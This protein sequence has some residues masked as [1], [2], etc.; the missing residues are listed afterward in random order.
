VVE[1]HPAVARVAAG[2][3][4]RLGPRPDQ[5]HLAPQDVQQLGQLIDAGGP[6]EAADRG[7]AHV[8]GGRDLRPAGARAHR[9]ELEHRERNAPLTDPQLPEED[10]TGTRAADDDRHHHEHRN[11][12][13]ERAERH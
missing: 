9:A 4:Q 7:D 13:Q 1:D 10:G 5:G 2:Q 6:Q 12:Q 3:R 8:V 11:Q